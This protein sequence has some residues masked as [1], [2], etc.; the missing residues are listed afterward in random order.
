MSLSTQAFYIPHDTHIQFSSPVV[1]FSLLLSFS[2]S[3]V[4]NFQ[5]LKSSMHFRSISRKFLVQT[6]FI[7]VSTK[8]PSL[9]L[10]VMLQLKSD[11]VYV[12]CWDRQRCMPFFTDKF[13][14]KT[15][16]CHPM[17]FEHFCYMLF[18]VSEQ[19]WNTFWSISCAYAHF[20]D[21]FFWKK[22]TMTLEYTSIFNELKKKR[23][24]FKYKSSSRTHTAK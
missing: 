12:N 20:I 3:I 17:Y 11:D 6:L 14:M 23:L 9:V 13:S 8:M 7:W 4:F 19:F 24:S 22:R 10:F 21:F 2:F 5:H 18:F 15:R 1:F 16:A